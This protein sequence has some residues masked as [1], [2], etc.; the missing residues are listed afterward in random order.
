M[1]DFKREIAKKISEITKLNED[2]LEQYVEIPPNSDLGDY[3]FPCFKLAKELHNAPA[4]IAYYIKENMNI[5]DGI[6]EKLSVDGGY[7]NIFINKQTLVRNVLEEIN[8]TGERYGSSDLG[9]GK[10]VVI[11][12]SAPNIAK[13]FHIGHLRSTVIGGALYKIYNFLG[14][15]S[16][17]IN[18]LGDWGLQ[19][20]KVMAGYELWKKEYDFNKSEIDAIL[21]IYT[22]FTAE[23]KEKPQLTDLARAHFKKLEDGDPEAVKTWEWIRRIS[24]EH[25][26][27]TYKMLNSK[28]DSYNGEAYYNDKMDEVIDELKDKGLLRESEGAQIVDLSPYDMPPCIIL[29]SAGTTIY[30][31]RD[32]A[33][34]K[35]RMRKYDFDKAIYVVANEQQLHFKQIFKVFELMGYSEYSKKCV[36]I[37]FGLVV[38]RDGQR[39]GTRRGN[40]VFLQ[41]ILNEAIDKVRNIINEKNPDLKE[42]D[43]IAEKVGVGAI[44]FNDL[45]SGRM[46]DEIFEWDTIL[47]FQGETGPYIQYIY[48]R[49]KSVIEKAAYV[50]DMGKVNPDKLTEKEVISIFKLIYNFGEVIKS[51]ADKNEP[52]VLARY[53]IDLAQSYSIF[54]NEHR[55]MAEDKETQDA[56][57]Y[58]SYITGSVL[59][60]GA[61]LLGM[62]MPD[63]M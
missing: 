57:L 4:D 39:I 9:Q 5:E 36:H 45:S 63:K 26:E 17:G 7:L 43:E 58:L 44:I 18:Y 10:N 19:F 42:K 34:L 23:E 22:R 2:E 30:A 21:K 48:V 28:F 11:D 62:E 8:V 31:T 32:L 3:A 54:Y 6:I 1:I 35:D 33:S 49:T 59:K 14:Y 55:I 41:D 25:Y 52:A 16:V 20:G 40:S 61:G 24:L 13:S 50:P 37:P 29:T 38:D 47:N 27:I 60:T 51:A 53:L 56:R 15:N 46:N 12:Y